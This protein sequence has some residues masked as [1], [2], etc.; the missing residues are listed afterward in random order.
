MELNSMENFSKPWIPSSYLC[1]INRN[2]YNIDME[3]IETDV[4]DAD[5]EKQKR[6]ER[7]RFVYYGMKCRL[8]TIGVPKRKFLI[9]HI[10]WYKKV[11]ARWKRKASQI[12]E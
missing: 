4:A 10:Y 7:L 1:F 9:M 12:Q 5:K 11:Q 8:Q 3:A 6:S 2:R